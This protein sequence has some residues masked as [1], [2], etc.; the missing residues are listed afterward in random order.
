[1][2]TVTIDILNERAINLLMELEAL[3]LIKM[4]TIK[5]TTE[6]TPPAKKA[7]DYKGIIS[8]ELGDKMQDHIR[9]SREEWQQRS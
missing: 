2:K 9:K 4:L 3:N 1:M 6:E 7:S 8:P 5:S